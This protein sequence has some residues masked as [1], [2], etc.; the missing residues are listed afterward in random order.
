MVAQAV[1][2][3]TA[4]AELG[5]ASVT[6]ELD[7]KTDSCVVKIVEPGQSKFPK[8]HTEVLGN[9]NPPRRV[10]MVEDDGRFFVKI[11]G[12]HPSLQRVFGKHLGGDKGFVN[13]QST[14]AH[15]TIGEI[16]SQQL[17]I[18]AVEREASNHPERFS[19]PSSAF[20][21]QQEFIPRFV[22][23]VQIILLGNE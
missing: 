6:A 7:G 16:V 2:I 18:Y 21:R 17:A 4:G 19:D 3:A 1:V 11:Y 13:D 14:E 23:L 22:Q 10:D 9:E 5:T 8:I 20:A 12:R 15:A